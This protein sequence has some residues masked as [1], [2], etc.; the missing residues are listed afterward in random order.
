M[1]KIYPSG[2]R[3]LNAVPDVTRELETLHYLG[4]HLN[5]HYSIYHGIH[6]TRIQEQNF[7]IF[8]EIDFVIVGPTGKILLIEQKTGLLEETH[9][10]LKKK[11][12]DKTKDISFQISRNADNFQQR[13]K[14]S[15]KDE[16]IYL[17]SLLYCPDYHVLNK[18]SAGIPEERIIDKSRK[19]RLIKVIQEI[20][21]DSEPDTNKN[22]KLH[23]FLLDILE[24]VPDVNLI[25]G[26]ANTL[27]TKLSG[28]L[29][30]WAQCL[31][32]EP[33]RLRVIGTAGSGKTQLAVNVYR[34]SIKAKRKP[35]YICYN[36]PLADHIAKIVPEGGEVAAYIQFADRLA[37]KN[38]FLINYSSENRY[39]EMEEFIN[40]FRPQPSDLFDDLIV[41]EG[42]DMNQ[43]WAS[44]LLKMIQ[45]NG[46][47]W[48]LEDPMQ[49]LYSRDPVY[50]K[51]WVTIYSQSNYRT[52]KNIL[53]E[54]NLI[55]C[56]QK[57]IESESPIEGNSVDVIFYSEKE[58]LVE[59]TIKGID[60]AISMG[61][62][63][64]QI[65]LLTYRGRES[66]ALSPY[67]QIGKYKLRAP[68]HDYDEYGNQIY[69][70]G[71][72][73]IDSVHRFKGRSAPCVVLTEIDFENFDESAK[74]RIFVGVTR[75]TMTLIMIMSRRSKDIILKGIN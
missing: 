53:N 54:L 55:L 11:Y 45:D 60:M 75:A 32:F 18:S 58:S 23:N 65:A 68:Q 39:A 19:E 66:S 50:L 33:F 73:E 59:K 1:A 27:Y 71:D 7:S 22:S 46:R 8:G 15:F 3:E 4:Q 13:L 35:L 10:G 74:R 48:W 14:G 57:Q 67:T 25:I 41:D 40:N 5:D 72:L 69:S 47:V 42:Q 63:P 38:N 34:Q 64:Q 20:L 21:P 9:K 24:I 61:Y 17:D 28:G 70:E 56:L 6:W 37:K 52:P 12:S 44:N 30:Q 26:E 36:R 29:A 31:D 16:K 2:W 51:N 43:I 62:K 49:N